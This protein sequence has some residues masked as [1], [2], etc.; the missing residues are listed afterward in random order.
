MTRPKFRWNLEIIIGIAATITSACAL[1]VS[2][3]QARYSYQQQEAM[4]FPYLSC[5][6]NTSPTNNEQILSNDGL[7][8]AF[9]SKVEMQLGDTTYSSIAE[10]YMVF[11]DTLKM[12]YKPNFIK[13]DLLPG[14]VVKA[15]ERRSMWAIQFKTPLDSIA[16]TKYYEVFNR[17]FDN[18]KQVIKIHYV[19]IYGNCYLFNS[20]K[21]LVERVSDCPNKVLK[22]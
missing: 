6:F 17:K 16:A 20:D 19:D 21:N 13:S 11:N 7:G 14:W 9:I 10:P 1:I 18:A 15:G 5:S 4:V 2:V 8:P 3:M 12:S 22:R